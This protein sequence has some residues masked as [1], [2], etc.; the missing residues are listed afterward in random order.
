MAFTLSPTCFGWFRTAWYT[1]INCSLKSPNSALVGRSAKKRQAEPANGSTYRSNS[2][3]HLSKYGNSFR[4]LPAQRSIGCLANSLVAPDLDIVNLVAGRMLGSSRETATRYAARKGLK[5]H[6]VIPFPKFVQRS[7]YHMQPN[8]PRPVE[9]LAFR[10]LGVPA[11]FINP[12]VS[13]IAHA[14]IATW[15]CAMMAWRKADS[16]ILQKTKRLP[17]LL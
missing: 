1:C 15:Y 7:G 17:S 3:T 14:Q 9:L 4:L 16:A 11:C 5:T 10:D 2:G 8:C 12:R 13:C 6:K